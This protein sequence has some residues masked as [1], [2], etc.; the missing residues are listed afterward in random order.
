MAYPIPDRV[1]PSGPLAA[2]NAPW[3]EY[4]G[5]RLVFQQGE[6]DPIVSYAGKIGP[7]GGALAPT[8]I[9]YSLGGGYVPAGNVLGMTPLGNDFGLTPGQWLVEADIGCGFNSSVPAQEN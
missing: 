8:L 4:A 6:E 3:A 7:S 2:N 1:S 9:M 5:K